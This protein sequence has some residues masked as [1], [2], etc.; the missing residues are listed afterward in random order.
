MPLHKVKMYTNIDRA[1]FWANLGFYENKETVSRLE[2]HAW[3]LSRKKW[4]YGWSLGTFSKVRHFFKL[5]T[6]SKNF[7]I[8]SILCLEKFGISCQ[9]SYYY[10]IKLTT[11]ISYSLNQHFFKTYIRSSLY[12]NFDQLWKYLTALSLKSHLRKFLIIS[13]TLVVPYTI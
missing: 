6:F 7:S 4:N 2:S 12:I 13:K 8:C 5:K 10:F 11:K 1:V 3:Q 9:I